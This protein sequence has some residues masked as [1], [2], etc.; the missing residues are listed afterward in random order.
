VPESLELADIVR[1]HG[2][3]LRTRWGFLPERVDRAFRDIGTCRTAALGGHLWVCN[4]C[5]AEQ[6]HYNSCRNRHCPKCQWKE[7]EAWVAAR[8]EDLLP[9][10][11]FHVVFTVPHLLRPLFRYN[12]RVLYGLLFS[13]V[14]RTLLTLAADPRRLGAEIGVIAVLHTWSQTLTLHPHVHCVVTGG[15]LSPCGQWISSGD[16]F[17]LPVR[18]L[19]KLFRGI[20]LADL[21]RRLRQGDLCLPNDLQ[22][23][24]LLVADLLGQLRG[25]NW[26]VYAKP[27]FGGPEKVLAYLG[28]YTHRTAISNA[29]L[30]EL[31]DGRVTFRYKRRSA[32]G[33][34]KTMTLDV[35]EFLRR[36]AGHVLPKGFVRIRYWGLLANRNRREKLGLCREQL[37]AAEPAVDDSG[38][39]PPSD[40][41]EQLRERPA[42]PTFPHCGNG[43]LVI[44]APLP[45]VLAGH[46]PQSRAPP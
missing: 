29:R 33:G 9:I 40:E 44:G 28:R 41:D 24:P 3:D 31:R 32:D 45:R 25:R 7:R 16:R 38:E 17:F 8:Q 11:Y 36:F 34:W 39:E 35:L 46:Q 20:F 2:E 21:E 22:Q 1:G 30:L 19:G 5:G 6:P 13:A 10:P 27:P 26:V 18:V 43:L 15:G 42:N 14:R 37:G 23:S 12:S 4:E